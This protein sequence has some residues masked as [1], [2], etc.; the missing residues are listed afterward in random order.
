MGGGGGDRGPFQRR[1]NARA[2]RRR[3]RRRSADSMWGRPGESPVV[4]STMREQLAAA[5]SLVRYGMRRGNDKGG[6]GGGNLE[7]VV[8]KMPRAAL[9][10]PRLRG[11]VSAPA[12]EQSP[13]WEHAARTTGTCT[14]RE[15]E[16]GREGGREGESARGRERKRERERDA[17][18]DH[19]QGTRDGIQ[20]LQ[21]PRGCTKARIVRSCGRGVR[22]E[23]AVAG[24][25]RGHG[26]VVN[27]GSVQ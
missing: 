18:S 9:V 8:V 27:R 14:V 23:S 19:G 11:R 12:V 4:I 7:N 26:R 25:A 20:R 6:G 10:V 17:L 16:G 3:A 15:R 1:A 21:R 5:H 24:G 2:R 13:N 22:A